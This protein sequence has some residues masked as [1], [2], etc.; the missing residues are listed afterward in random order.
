MKK[1]MPK[2]IYSRKNKGYIVYYKHFSAFGKT[3][4][5]AWK[6]FS[7][8]LSAVIDILEEELK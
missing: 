3:K 1:V 6:Y 5:Q 7:L 2:I 4:E 8:V